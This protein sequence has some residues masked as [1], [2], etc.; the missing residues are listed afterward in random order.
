[1]GMNMVPTVP[2]PVACHRHTL[3]GLV[4]QR[5]ARTLPLNIA[6]GHTR[7]TDALATT[8]THTHTHPPTRTQRPWH[9]VAV[10]VGW[11]G[12]EGGGGG[13][14]RVTRSAHASRNHGEVMDHQAGDAPV[15]CPSFVFGPW[16]GPTL[17]PTPHTRIHFP[18]PHHTRAPLCSHDEPYHCK[19]CVP[20]TMR[21]ERV[22][23][24]ALPP[25][26][27]SR[28]T[29]VGDRL[30]GVLVTMRYAALPHCGARTVRYTRTRV[31]RSTRL[32]TGSTRYNGLHGTL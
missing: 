11:G 24:P 30:Y 1:M 26:I 31:A 2:P 6:R 18:I 10:S 25:P 12:G 3:M 32:L 20:S 5:S 22:L 16:L 17:H 21:L 19:G 13:S 28:V 8:H 9:R 29:K 15:H 23:T 27:Q 14:I 4:R 7:R